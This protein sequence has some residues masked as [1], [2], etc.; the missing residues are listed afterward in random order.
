MAEHVDTC[1]VYRDKEWAQLSTADLVPGDIIQIIPN[2]IVPM[3]GVILQGDIV[4]DESSLT[5]EPLPIRKFPLRPQAI[6]E[7][8][9]EFD[10]QSDGKINSLFAGTTIK[11]VTKE[12]GKIPIVLVLKTRTNTDKGQLVQRILFPQPISFIFNEQLKLVFC[13]L[14]LWAIVLL[15]FGAWLLG[16]TGMTAWFYGTICAAQV[17]NPLLPGKIIYIYKWFLFYLTIILINSYFGGWTIHCS[18]KIKKEGC[19]LCRFT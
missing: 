15:G 5:G 14:L 6:H 16:G 8:K 17:M 11:Q 3:D 18:R 2:Q 10:P 12:N 19:I 13:L 9:E 7:Q 1:Q 4:V